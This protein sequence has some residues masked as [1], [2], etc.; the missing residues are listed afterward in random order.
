ML[1]TA[2]WDQ[3]A[4]FLARHAVRYMAI[5]VVIA[6]LTRWAIWRRARRPD[7]GAQPERTAVF[8]MELTVWARYL[9]MGLILGGTWIWHENESP[10]AH[11][12]RV[13]ILVIFVAPIIRWVR[14]RYADHS[15]RGRGPGARLHG[16]LEAK[17]VLLVTAL[18]IELL[19]DKWLSRP[20][21]DEIV[22]LWLGITVAVAG[23]LLHERLMAGWRR[24]SRVAPG[25][26]PSKVSTF[27]DRRGD[28]VTDTAGNTAKT[29]HPA[30]HV[31]PGSVAHFRSN[32]GRPQAGHSRESA[33]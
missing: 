4:G 15:S 10:W 30:D 12:L 7:G 8:G 32:S 1:A 14:Q 6:G 29:Q 13:V 25:S 20:A 9:V 19:L 28:A 24:T 3:G 16:W 22:A 27:G 31:G 11:A 26:P 2:L 5:A 18:V 23:P 33:V 21:T 17:L